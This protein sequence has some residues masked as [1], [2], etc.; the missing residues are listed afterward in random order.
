[1]K[2]DITKNYKKSSIRS[3]SQS[4]KC[5][6]IKDKEKDK[7]KDINTEKDKYPPVLRYKNKYSITKD[8]ASN[9]S[10]NY[11]Y[12]K[13]EIIKDSNSNKSKRYQNTKDILISKNHNDLNNHSFNYFRKTQNNNS[14]LKNIESSCNSDFCNPTKS[15]YG[16]PK[17]TK[18][19]KNN[20]I[21]TSN[22]NNNNINRNNFILPF[23]YCVKK[24]EKKYNV[25]KK[26]NYSNK[27]DY[28]YILQNLNVIPI[29]QLAIQIVSLAER[30]W[31]NEIK[32]NLSILEKN[33]SISLESNILNE[34]IK[35]RLIIQEDFNWLLWAVSYVFQNKIIINANNL[36]INENEKKINFNNID[37]I[38]KIISVDDINK[39]K[40]GFIY[41]GVYFCLFDKIENYREIKEIKREIKSL[42]L[43]FLDYIQILDNIPTNRSNYESKHLLCN[44]ILFPL[45]SLAE[46]SNYYILASMALEPSFTERNIKNNLREKDEF[47]YNYYN[48]VDLSKYNLNNLR[49]SPFFVNLSE[50]NILNLNNRKFL[51]VNIAKDLHPLLVPKSIDNNDNIYKNNF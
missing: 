46:I 16:I 49:S 25:K 8:N 21:Y 40:E 44:N 13:K 22:N 20:I 50:N 36:K 6:K 19:D 24:G 34:F 51:L 17:I 33:K 15:N 39:W 12:N 30:G 42:N 14:I 35:E 23:Y 18:K 41:N 10:Y 26:N 4:T 1:M 2:I 5:M 28:Y 43:L 31:L 3:I 45:L 9:H 7:D 38:N 37:D 27:N 48:E 29:S 32:D 47:I 11:N